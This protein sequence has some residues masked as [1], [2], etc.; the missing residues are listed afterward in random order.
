MRAA[1]NEN[2]ALSGR[3][4]LTVRH[5]LRGQHPGH[6]AAVLHLPLLLDTVPLQGCLQALWTSSFPTI[7]N[8]Q[9]QE[10]E[11]EQGQEQEVAKV[12][13]YGST[14]M[15]PNGNMTIR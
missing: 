3:V 14:N 4:V 9:E 2:L 1:S 7:G 10:K 13:G 5:R 12:S 11:Q 15:K 6:Q 8:I